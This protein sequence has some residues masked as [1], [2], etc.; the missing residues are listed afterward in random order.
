MKP[1]RLTALVAGV[2]AI[3]AF[4]GI[5]LPD[6]AGSGVSAG[7]D[8]HTITVSGSGSVSAAPTKAVFDFGVGTRSRT[9]AQ[10]LAEDSA[11]MRRLIDA[12][13]SAGVP[14]ASLQTTSVSLSPVTNSQG[15]TI[16]GYTASNSVSA[17]IAE[18]THAGSIVDTAVVAGAN[19]VDGP[20]LTVADQDALY[21]SALQAAVADARAKAGSLAAAGGLHVGAVTSIE[22]SGDT[23]PVTAAAGRSPGPSTPIAPGTEQI[24]ASVTVVFEAS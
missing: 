10:A 18:L 19:E 8:A 23:S 24:A 22:E 5:G 11:Q 3:V 16:V 1:V 14:A 2:A 7:Q 15:D 17:T 4:A 13:E 21:R 9:A 12:L 20:N 6:R